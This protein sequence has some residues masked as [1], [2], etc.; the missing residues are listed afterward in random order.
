VDDGYLSTVNSGAWYKKE[1]KN[2]VK[3]PLKDFLVPICFT[4]DE[5]GK[6]DKSR[7]QSDSNSFISILM[8]VT[9]AT[10][11]FW[12]P[13]KEFQGIHMELSN[14][15]GFSPDWQVDWHLN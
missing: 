6:H 1:Y 12:C 2:L 10:Q 7:T 4:C 15:W 9:E 3:D 14:T 5:G 13:L 11:V 8:E